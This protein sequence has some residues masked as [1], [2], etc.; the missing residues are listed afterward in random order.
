MITDYVVY[1]RGTGEIIRSGSAP[2]ATIPTKATEAREG[3]VRGAGSSSRHYVELE[4]EPRVRER[5]KFPVSVEPRPDGAVLRGV[6]VGTRVFHN[7]ALAGVVDDGVVEFSSS[8]TG[9]HELRLVRFPY[10]D[11]T[12]ELSIT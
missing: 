6:P 3:V 11:H 12:L 9:T 2:D 10:L 7:G 4:P 1:D 5:P 8:L